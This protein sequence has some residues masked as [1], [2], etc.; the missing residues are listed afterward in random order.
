MKLGP[1]FR[2][3]IS[4]GLLFSLGATT[5]FAAP[6]AWL[7]NVAKTDSV[8]LP[9]D[10]PAVVLLDETLVMIQNDGRETTRH[11]CAIRILNQSGRQFA[12]G[13][14]GYLE[15]EDDVSST[16]AWVVR[17]GK[18]VAPKEKPKWID[19]SAAAAGEIFSEYR[20]R[21]VSYSDFALN[22]DVFGYETIVEGNLNFP[23]LSNSWES[24]LP[25]M[26]ESY[27]LQLPHGWTMQ[28]VVNGPLA[29]VL[30]TATGLQSWTWELIDRPYRPDEPDMSGSGRIDARLMITL[31]PPAELP[32]GMLPVFHSWADLDSWLVA[33]QDPQ[34]DTNPALTKTVNQLTAGSATNQESKSAQE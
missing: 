18:A 33:L 21:V 10:A 17:A 6:P 3:I 14:V 4:S 30:R 28:A 12:E 29:P 16:D 20:R 13:E 15:K 2:F 9:H 32:R 5:T 22:D 19:E 11:R 25:V 27:A 7:L 31:S 1:I 24:V 26:R 34:C 23:Q 8:L